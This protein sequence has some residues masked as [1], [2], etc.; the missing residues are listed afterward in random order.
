MLPRRRYQRRHPPH[1]L[2]IHPFPEGNGRVARLLTTAY[3]I[4]I[5]VGDN[6]LWTATR[7]FARK[8][9]EYDANLARADRPRRNDLDGRG[10][11][12]EEDLL[13]FCAYFLRCC[14]DQIAYMNGMLELHDLG[15]RY[16]RYIGG[17][18]SDKQVSK[19]GAKV[20]ERVLLLGEVPRGEVAGICGVKKRR[21]TQIVKELLDEKLTRSESAYGPLRLSISADMAAVLFPQLA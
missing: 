4:R 13:E 2:W 18:V 10:P 1:K 3:G 16:N 20:M 8:R 9:T 17:L 14:E 19:A 6:V 21:V 7:A 5:G 12:S 15:R 11:L